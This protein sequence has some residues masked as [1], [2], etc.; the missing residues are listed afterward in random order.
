MTQ[1]LQSITPRQNPVN[2]TKEIIPKA[3]LVS[4]A[5]LKNACSYMPILP[6]LFWVLCSSITIMK[7][8]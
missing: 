5:I 1:E 2:I 8:I 4:N 7:R 3:L 6:H